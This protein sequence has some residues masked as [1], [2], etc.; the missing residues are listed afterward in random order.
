MTIIH[1]NRPIQDGDVPVRQLLV[2]QRVW[3]DQLPLDNMVY[4]IIYLYIYIHIYIYID[5]RSLTR[6]IGKSIDNH[7]QCTYVY[8]YT[9]IYIYII[10]SWYQ[11]I[12]I[13]Y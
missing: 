11:D 10:I 12:I 9:Y 6:V 8:T 2:Y 4:V 5:N 3:R 7:I 13:L 1:G